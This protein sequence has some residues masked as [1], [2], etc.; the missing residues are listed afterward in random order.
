MEMSCSG[1]CRSRKGWRWEDLTGGAIMLKGAEM[2]G[3]VVL[4]MDFDG[5]KGSVIKAEYYFSKLII[6]VMY[7]F[8]NIF[9]QT[10]Y[11]LQRL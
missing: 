11:T 5:V 7:H 10:I 1:L 3:N 6:S 4:Y 8:D 9:N 2:L